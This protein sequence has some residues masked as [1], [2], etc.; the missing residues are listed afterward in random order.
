MIS[1]VLNLTKGAAWPALAHHLWQSTACLGLAVLLTSA[2]RRNRAYIRYWVWLAASAKFLLPFSALVYLGERLGWRLT[3]VSSPL[4]YWFLEESSAGASSMVPALPPALQGAGA[5]ILPLV[6]TGIWLLGAVC[7]LARWRSEWRRSRMVVREAVLLRTGSEWDALQR[8]RCLTSMSRSVELAIS[9]SAIE[10]GVFGILRPTIILPEAILRR[11]TVEQ[12]EAI[13]SHEL[14]HI[15]RRDN[16]L[17][18]MHLSVEAVFWFHPL[19]W[20]VRTRL[21]VERERACDEAVLQS[22]RDP[23]AYAEAILV[24]CRFCLAAPAACVAG[25][26]NA[27]IRHRVERI[28]SNTIGEGLNLARRAM[29]TATAAVT[30][31]API[32]IGLLTAPHSRA[33]L[34]AADASILPA[35]SFATIKPSGPET[36]LKVDFGPGGRLVISHATLR[37]LMKIAYDVGDNQILGGPKW[38]ESRRFDLEAKPVPALGGDPRNMTEDERRA[39]HEQVRLRLQRLLSDRFHLRVRTEAKEMPIFALVAAKSGA[40]LRESQSAGQPE[41]KSGHGQYTGM[42]VSLEQFA[43][44]LSEGQTGRPVVDMT[45]LKGVFDIHL[46]WSPDPGQSLSALDATNATPPPA[47][48]G[49]VTIFTALQQQLGLKLEGRKSPSD[50]LFVVSADLPSEN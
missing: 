24:V 34:L 6:F 3:P 37:F 8:C 48:S 13:L 32:V 4:I 7:V 9:R 36:R 42:R 25:V 28:M 43:R 44:F 35:F 26:T 41:M 29:L 11:L 14:A 22:G 23:Q 2:L 40:K 33:Q 45:D 15:R 12:L 38:L 27:D 20:W 21:L 18:A 39:M 31:L 1:E 17:A 47:D 10:P 50:C 19:L 16:L 49:G 30:L 5:P 46:Q